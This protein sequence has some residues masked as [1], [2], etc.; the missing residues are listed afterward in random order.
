MSYVYKWMK[1]HIAISSAMLEC[2]ENM[3][4]RLVAKELHIVACE[5]H[6]IYDILYNIKCLL[7]LLQLVH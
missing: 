3:M 6:H 5:L 7:Q 2:H 4:W 1:S